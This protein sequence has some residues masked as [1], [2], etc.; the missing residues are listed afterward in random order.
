M[1][2]IP[3]IILLVL[4][5]FAPA[6]LHATMVDFHHNAVI[7]E[8][9]SYYRVSVWDDAIVVMT[10]GEVTFQLLQY[11]S[12]TVTVIDGSVRWFEL[13]DSSTA[14]L[15]GGNFDTLYAPGPSSYFNIYGYDFTIEKPSSLWRL[16]GFWPDGLPLEMYLRRA[17]TF[18]DHY[19]IHEVPE[20]ATI[21]LLAAGVVG[22]R[23]GKFGIIYESDTEAE[24]HKS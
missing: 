3:I 2:K 4:T 1:H 10:G 5:L 20:P 15:Y 11:D 7:Q 16:T 6:K 18:G 21:L 19:L 12:S 14:N 17:D 9:D 23:V 22:L 13:R 8:G 24:H